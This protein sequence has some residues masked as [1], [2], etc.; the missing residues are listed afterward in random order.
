MPLSTNIMVQNDMVAEETPPGLVTA[1]PHHRKHPDKPGKNLP[2]F[3]EGLLPL[4][5]AVPISR[6]FCF[7]K[8]IRGRNI[9]LFLHLHLQ[10]FSIA[11]VTYDADFLKWGFPE[12][13]SPSGCVSVLL[14]VLV[15]WFMW[16]SKACDN[17]IALT[18]LDLSMSQAQK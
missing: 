2:D 3:G 4:L 18:H 17:H 14:L 13:I 1:L 5:P 16:V 6:W 7:P 10:L 15:V 12:R 8:S 9:S 11:I